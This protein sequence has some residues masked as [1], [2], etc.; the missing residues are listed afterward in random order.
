MK[1][2]T[3]TNA[4]QGFARIPLFIPLLSDFSSYIGKSHYKFTIYYELKN[5][6]LTET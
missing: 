6:L 3:Q 5:I 2:S 1:L 4:W